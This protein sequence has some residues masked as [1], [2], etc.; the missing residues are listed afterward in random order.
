[1]ARNDG[2]LLIEDAEIRFRNF[3]GKEGMYNQEG[4]RNF[5]VMLDPQLA[6]D[7][8]RDNWNVKFLKAR[9]EGEVPQA[10]LQVSVKYRGRD[11]NPTRPPTIVMITS[12]G[13]TGL[14]EEECEI[15]DWVDIAKA[16]LIIRPFE[17]AMQGKSGVKAYL[18]SLYV[19]IEEDVLQLRYQD[20]PEIGAGGSAAITTGDDVWD[21]EVVEDE[22]KAITR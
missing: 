19:T 2:R 17:W 12:K 11:G 10:Y 15:L 18:Q 5:C 22:Q 16:D 6:E 1:M 9:E 21:A 13:R 20:L 8:Q 3:A 7:L 4:A 14:D